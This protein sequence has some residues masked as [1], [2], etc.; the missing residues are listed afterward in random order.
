MAMDI[1]NVYNRYISN[2]AHTSRNSNKVTEDSSKTSQAQLSPKAQKLLEKL[3][4]TYGNV[5]FM[6]ADFDKKEEVSEDHIITGLKLTPEMGAVI[7]KD[8]IISEGW[9]FFYPT[10]TDENG[11][12]VLSY[13][14]YDQKTQKDVSKNYDVQQDAPGKLTVLHN[15]NLPPDSITVEKAKTTYKL[16]EA[17]MVNDLKVTA[18]YGDGYT[19]AVPKGGGHDSLTTNEEDIDMTTLGGKTLTVTYTREVQEYRRKRRYRDNPMLEGMQG[20][21]LQMI[22]QNPVSRS[23]GTVQAAVMEANV[24]IWLYSEI[25][26]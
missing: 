21:F 7:N 14:I 15:E 5:D 16:G 4:K 17:L 22:Q 12:K 11:D 3:K 25:S 2:Y 19:E 1:S 23:M 26:M 8:G 9:I 18:R 6:V 13:A 20:N 10:K 24:E